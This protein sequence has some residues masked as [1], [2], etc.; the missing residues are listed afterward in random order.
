MPMRK[1]RQSRTELERLIEAVENGEVDAIEDL[2]RE[3]VALLLACGRPEESLQDLFDRL[4]NGE[5]T[6]E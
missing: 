1:A 5:P 6:G 2:T 3:E 4:R